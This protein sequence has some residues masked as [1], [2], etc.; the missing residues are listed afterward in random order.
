MLYQLNKLNWLFCG[1][2]ELVVVVS[3]GLVEGFPGATSPAA[4]PVK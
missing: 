1:S 2:V 3:V 4:W